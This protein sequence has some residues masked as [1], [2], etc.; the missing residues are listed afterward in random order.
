MY[1]ASKVE[2]E[3]ALWDFMKE[4]KPSF[5]ANAVLPN[6]NMGTVLPN[7]SAGATGA[8]VPGLYNGKLSPLS[9]RQLTFVPAVVEV[10]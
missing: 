9:P 3:K 6:F 7:G 2:G 8:A 10:Y 5:T 4:Q 1:A